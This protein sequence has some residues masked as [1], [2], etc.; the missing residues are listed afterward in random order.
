MTQIV[1]TGVAD[2]QAQMRAYVA[3]VE[4][5]QRRVA[6]YWAAV[7]EEYAKSNA[8][9]TDRTGNARQH[10]HGY[11]NGAA[12]IIPSASAGIDQYPDTE[13][14]ASD[15]VEIYLAHGMVYGV[16]LELEF[17]GRY[18]I[19]WETINLHLPQIQKM[20]QEVFD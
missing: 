20:L 9:W 4:A 15:T 19:I 3:K 14:L 10:L 12:P 11:L 16:G 6:Q 8:A 7:F 18:A 13:Q 17:A 2:L 5:A 1:W